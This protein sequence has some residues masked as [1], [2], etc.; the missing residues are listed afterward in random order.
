MD[1]QS[2]KLQQKPHRR[3]NPL[4]GEWVL[5]SPHRGNRPWL[6]KQEKTPQ[7]TSIQYDRDC[8]L[9]PGNIRINGEV[10]DNYDDIFVFDNDFPAILDDPILEDE[11]TN[12]LF[13]NEPIKGKCRVLCFSPDHNKTMADLELDSIE[14]VITELKSQTEELS[15][16][17]QTVQI[18]E[19][20]GEIMGCSNPHPH[21]QIW[22]NSATPTEINKE[23]VTQQNY[24]NK[25]KSKMLLDY[26]EQELELGQ[27]ILLENDHWA[28][29][30]PYW[31]KWPFETMIL[32]KFD[33][34][35]FL[36]LDSQ[37]IES[38]AN[39]TKTHLQM[40]NNLFETPMPYSMGWHQK[41]FDQDKE[42]QT[43][44]WQ[45]HA[46]YYPPLLRSATNQKFMVG[47]EMMAEP[48]RDFTAELAAQK[49]R[50]NIS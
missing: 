31:A 38:L 14:K 37:Q 35:T 7:K 30:V 24:W 33:A 13:I 46:H 43:R 28:T 22:A 15:K 44:G 11:N 50:E 23:L 42:K 6:G 48:Q 41:P 2:D 5:V 10:N 25:N 4:T 29:L 34:N 16:R 26:L 32:P 17:F 47:Y 18:F 39:I 9:C 49:L 8:L 3:L 36:D 20:K 19:N 40:Y 12:E 45:L 21:C 27:R 1:L